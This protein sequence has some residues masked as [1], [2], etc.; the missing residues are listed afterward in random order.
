MLLEKITDIRLGVVLSRK[1]AE[2]DKECERVYRMLT[3]K[4]FEED[5]CVDLNDLENFQSREELNLQ[6]LT[7]KGDVVIRITIPYTAVYINEA[8][9]GCV[10]PSNFAVIRLFDTELFLPEFIALYLNSDKLKRE[11]NR[12][13][14]GTAIPMIK[15]SQL[16][17]LNIRKYSKTV[18]ERLIKVNKLHIKEKK[19]LMALLEEKDLL[20]KAVIDNILK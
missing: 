1:K 20:N 14:I 8:L 10:I 3:L 2:S 4:S 18:Q 6:Y 5:G 19:L 7:K 11:F 12:A 16:K 13:S 15:A 9:E 17:E